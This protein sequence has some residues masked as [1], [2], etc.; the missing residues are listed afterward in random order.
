MDADPVALKKL[1]LEAIILM[2]I[3]LNILLSSLKSD[4]H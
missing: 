1:L 2:S 4:K 3:N